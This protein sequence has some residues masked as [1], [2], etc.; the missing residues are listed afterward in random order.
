MSCIQNMEK[1]IRS[2]QVSTSILKQFSLGFAPFREGSINTISES[3]KAFD[4][5]KYKQWLAMA[6]QFAKE[7]GI[8]IN[9]HL[10]T[11]GIYGAT[12][13]KMEASSVVTIT[14][15]EEQTNLFAAL[16]GA[17]APE[18]QHSVM[19]NTY[20]KVGLDTEHRISF[21]DRKSAE[22]F[23]KNKE[24]FGVSDVSFDP[25]TNTALILDISRFNLIFNND[26]FLTDYGESITDHAINAI[27]NRFVEE[28]EYSGIIQK[29]WN[30]NTRYNRGDARQNLIDILHFAI[31]TIDEHS[32]YRS[33]LQKPKKR[34][35]SKKLK[36]AE[37]G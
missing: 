12:S 24:V 36:L 5:K 32:N 37:V 25:S 19:I 27:G 35:L 13:A 3:Q 14:A 8:T 34:A 20:D 15:T 11:L 4:S 22:S 18:V 23:L 21:K 9:T 30:N 16:M 7:I 31:T 2:L 17:L 26:K 6:N 28:E 10:N 33:A 1:K 29:A